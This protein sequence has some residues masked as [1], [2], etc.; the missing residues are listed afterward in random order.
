MKVMLDQNEF[1]DFIMIMLYDM[2]KNENLFDKNERFVEL[3]ED[4]KKRG[5]MPLL[6]KYYL[7]SDI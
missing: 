4:L 6:F 2:I 7:D 5:L 1:I 3:L